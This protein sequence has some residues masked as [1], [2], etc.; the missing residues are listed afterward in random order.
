V[1]VRS[2]DEAEVVI[3]MLLA[4]CNE[5]ERVQHIHEEEHDTF[6]RTPAWKR[7]IFMIDGWSGHRIVTTPTWR[8]WRRWWTS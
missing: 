6:L 5:L 1:R 2:L 7:W 4:K 8:P 3:G